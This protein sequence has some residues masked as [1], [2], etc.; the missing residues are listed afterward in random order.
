MKAGMDIPAWGLDQDRA[1]RLRTS[2]QHGS[3][4]LASACRGRTGEFNRERIKTRFALGKRNA[5]QHTEK[6][7][8][9]FGDYR[10]RASLLHGWRRRQ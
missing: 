4:M 9:R 8:G 3:P 10:F 2:W 5:E 1:E 6:E 7:E